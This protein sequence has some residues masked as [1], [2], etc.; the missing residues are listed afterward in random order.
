MGEEEQSLQ[1][2]GVSKGEGQIDEVSLLDVALIL[3]RGRKL[4]GIAIGCTVLFGALMAIIPDSEY[5]SEATVI[6]EGES[7]GVPS[8]LSALNRFGINLGGGSTGLN[9][10]SY[11]EILTSREVRLAVAR[12]TFAFSRSGNTM[13]YVEHANQSPGLLVQIV[14]T[15]RKYTVDLLDTVLKA[16]EEKTPPP[17]ST[18]DPSSGERIYP[19]PQE[20]RAMGRLMGLV[21]VSS[22]PSG[23]M[24][25]SVTTNDP[26]VSAQLVK[27]FVEHLRERVRDIRTE[28]ARQN[29]AFAEERFVEAER[30]LQEAEAELAQ[31]L[32]RNI[33]LQTA[34]LRMEEQRL[35]RQVSFKSDLYRDLQSQVT[36]ARLALQRSEPVISIVEQPVPARSPDGPP[37]ALTIVISLILGV[38]IGIG[39]AFI[40]AYI[41]MQRGE[42]GSS[43]EKIEEIKEALIPKRLSKPFKHVRSSFKKET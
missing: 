30:E 13:T 32:D 17:P 38:M 16:F 10:G 12:D 1:P 33:N 5:V 18:T 29:L 28:K 25:I 14:R 19:T 23:M 26:L 4:I 21:S 7:G 22:S 11:P 42:G 39:L 27:S 41:D 20:E 15:V 3:T 35:E 43:Q 34:R 2:N 9:A 8:S 36:Q 24:V 37:R 6:R 40:K 31:F